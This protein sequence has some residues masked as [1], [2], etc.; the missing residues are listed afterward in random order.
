M[1]WQ[2]I[3]KIF[4]FLLCY[5]HVERISCI[6][7]HSLIIFKKKKEQHEGAVEFIRELITLPHYKRLNMEMKFSM[8]FRLN[9]EDG[10]SV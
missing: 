8:K 4:F 5:N 1:E 2:A 10:V 3:R 9:Y 7:V 6:R